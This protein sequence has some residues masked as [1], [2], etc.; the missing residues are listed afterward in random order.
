MRVGLSVLLLGAL[1]AAALVG[2]A[3][4]QEFRL[5][6]EQRTALAVTVY[7]G[8]LALV[9]DQRAAVLKQGGNRL[10]FEGVSR[11]MIP[12]SAVLRSGAGVRVAEIDY[13]FDL[14]TPEAL[15]RRSVGREVEVVRTHPTTGEDT[16]ES[17]TLLSA[18]GGVVLRYRDRVE[19]GMPG[20]LVFK[21]LPED[22]RPLPS[23]V[24]S[25]I[26]GAAGR[27]ELELTYLTTGLS[28][29]ADYV[30]ELDEATGR[31]DIA[32]RATLTNVSGTDFRE[33]SLGLIAG[34]VNRV[35]QP[36][37]RPQHRAMEMTAAMSVADA[38]PMPAREAVGDLHLYRLERPVTI[39]DRQT[40]QIALLAAEGVP[41]MREYVS[42]AGVQVFG[43]QRG[44]PRP[45]H[46][47]V[48]LRFDNAEADGPGIPMP[49]GIA[50]VYARDS[51]G[52]P[53]LLGEDRLD[54]TPVGESVKL[55]PGDAFDI[56]VKRRQ[57]DFVRAGLPEGVFEASYRVEVN[58]AK[59]VEVTVK[60]VEIIP[61]DWT[62][63][64]ESASHET[65]SAGRLVWRLAVPAKGTAEMT[66]RVRVHR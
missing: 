14:L 34:R 61:G 49:A 55:T 51:A 60:L 40:K 43:R 62:I 48:V 58:N 25:L 32:G 64:E 41:F 37:P 45:T 66:Y 13:D 22:L 9:R 4:A 10:V 28:W 24:A 23:L 54:N 11:R 46:P 31:L 12:S 20:R 39:G 30:V 15:L 38:A 8:G 2:Q 47:Q 57:T 27:R 29:Q 44:E 35:S 3:G 19:T 6:A 42:E 52:A 5:G 50:R 53:Q 26:S 7:G 56:T 1:S 59:D 21:H 65:E 16:V 18:E 17:A 33:A 63:L 36:G